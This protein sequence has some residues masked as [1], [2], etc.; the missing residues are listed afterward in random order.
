MSVDDDERQVRLTPAAAREGGRQSMDRTFA[1][2]I[3]MGG[4]A[5]SE[6]FDRVGVPLI[7]SAWEGFNVSLFAYGQTGSGK[8]HTM[9]GFGDDRGVIPRICTSLFNRI[10]EESGGSNDGGSAT[11][12]LRVEAS[13]LEIYNEKIRDLLS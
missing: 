4:T 13:M 12:R 2:D 1:F 8:T 7:E 11:M 9:V 6:V 5:Q 3:A 10:A